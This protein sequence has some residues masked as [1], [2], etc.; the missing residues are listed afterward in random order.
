L[1]IISS[2]TR[3]LVCASA[4][5]EKRDARNKPAAVI[6]NFNGASLVFFVFVVV[7]DAAGTA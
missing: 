4:G 2:V 6:E 5:I 7:A 3:G 1:I